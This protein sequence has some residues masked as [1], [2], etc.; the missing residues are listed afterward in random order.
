MRS[1]TY[2]DE[3]AAGAIEQNAIDGGHV[4]AEVLQLLE[5]LVQ[6]RRVHHACVQSRAGAPHVHNARCENST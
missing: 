5:A 1:V 4:A 6:Q 3:T 2:R